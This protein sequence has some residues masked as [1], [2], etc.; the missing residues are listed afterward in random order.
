[1]K[2]QLIISSL[3]LI[4]LLVMMLS[5]TLAWF[6]DSKANVNTMVA[7]KISISQTENFEQGTII[8]PNVPITK[9]VVVTNTGNQPCYVRTLFA[10]EDK[11]YTDEN[12][13][14]KTVLDMLTTSGQ[15]IQ[16]PT[17]ASGNKIQFTVT[18]NGVTTTYTVGYY[19]H[20]S[21]LSNEENKSITVLNSIT[22]NGAADNEWQEAVGTDYELIVL[23]QASQVSGLNTLG[24][25]GAESPAAALNTAFGEV[26]SANCVKW[27]NKMLTANSYGQT[28]VDPVNP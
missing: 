12:G 14:T 19:V 17:D 22:L 6:T 15:N 8:L 20:Q 1:M 4:L 11:T 23:S 10:F 21:Q 18:K 3:C 13:A 26:N 25:N 5:T 16:F 24:E 28:S 7:G 2:R 27:F 9:E